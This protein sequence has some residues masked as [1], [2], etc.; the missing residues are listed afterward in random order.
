MVDL[1]VVVDLPLAEVA[2]FVVVV[3]FPL[4][5]EVA[6]V[7]VVVD[8]GEVAAVAGEAL[9]RCWKGGW[10]QKVWKRYWRGQ[11]V[12]KVEGDATGEEEE[13][14]WMVVSV[15]LMVVAVEVRRLCR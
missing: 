7:V 11:K 14:A 12:W 1:L 15:G 5:V 2:G 6:V 9:E 10:A 8:L 4:V 13:K 3:D